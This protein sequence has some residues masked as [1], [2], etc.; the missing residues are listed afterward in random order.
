LSHNDEDHDHN[1]PAIL[2]QYRKAINKVFFLQDRRVEEMKRTLAVLKEAE[3]GDY[4][5]PQRLEADSGAPRVVFSE[6]GITLAVMYPDLMA[7]VMAQDSAKG[8]PNQTSVIL[9]LTCGGRRI[10]FAGDATI[11]AWDYLSS[12]MTCEKPLS[13]DIITIPHHGGSVTSDSSKEDSAQGRLYSKIVRPEYGIASVGTNN[14][15]QHPS[16]ASIAALQKA[17]VKVLCTQMTQKC[18]DDLEAIRRVRSIVTRP[19]R[20]RA[21]STRRRAGKS[22]H[23]ACYGSIVAEVSSGQVRISGLKRW[24]KDFET[25]GGLTGF[26]PLC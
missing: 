15:H 17:G 11:E 25:F 9:R 18:C 14:Q 6:D 13:C 16:E 24:Q 26:H 1:A 10:V 12:K 22:K 4:P 19:A 3:E 21:D 5:A 2:T 20:S 8:R 7:N 23:V